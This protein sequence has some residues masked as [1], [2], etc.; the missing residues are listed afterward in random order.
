MCQKKSLKESV[1]STERVAWHFLVFSV[2]QAVDREKG[3]K[4]GKKG[5]KSGKKSG[6]KVSRA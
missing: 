6:K 3:G 2:L 5:K 4:K 1:R